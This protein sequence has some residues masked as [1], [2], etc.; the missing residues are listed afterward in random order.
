MTSARAVA[1][2]WS[3]KT[4]GVPRPRLRRSI[5]TA[6]SFALGFPGAPA[7]LLPRRTYPGFCM[8]DLR[9]G[10]R[11]G[12][13]P[14][15]PRRCASAAKGSHLGRG[16]LVLDRG[17]RRG[18]VGLPVFAGELLVGVDC[19][20]GGGEE[21][22]GLHRHVGCE[23]PGALRLALEAD[24][25]S[26]FVVAAVCGPGGRGAGFADLGGVEASR[27]DRRAD[28]GPDDA[29][30]VHLGRLVVEGAF[31]GL[32]HPLEGAH[33]LRADRFVF[34]NGEAEGAGD[35]FRD[36]LVGAKLEGHFEGEGGA[37]LTFGGGL[38]AVRSHFGKVPFFAVG[39][40]PI[41]SAFPSVRHKKA[42]PGRPAPEGP[43]RMRRTAKGGE[44]ASR[45]IRRRRR[46]NSSTAAVAGRT[47]W[48]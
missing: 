6:V 27:P 41:A 11:K 44:F 12:R 28:E 4:N 33:V 26:V 46:G 23:F 17:F 5:S 43:E 7:R 47:G 1:S 39:R 10:G 18:F 21:G 35:V 13:G 2:L 20:V 31:E 29:L 36:A 32:G 25:D 24:R 34:G 9:E 14:F 37:G 19:A 8:M 15:G 30:K 42:R 16:G 3:C 45:G 38:G 40:W 22:V 48:A